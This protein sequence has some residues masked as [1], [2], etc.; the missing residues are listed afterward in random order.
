MLLQSFIRHFLNVFDNIAR[1]FAACICSLD[2]LKLYNLIL[3]VV[4]LIQSF[5]VI[6]VQDK[7]IFLNHHHAHILIHLSFGNS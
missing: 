3:K 5:L 2:I 4:F 7:I 1:A 6:T